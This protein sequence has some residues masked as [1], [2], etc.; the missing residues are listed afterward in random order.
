MNSR[1]AKSTTSPRADVGTAAAICSPVAGRPG[2]VELAR[3]A[4][5]H[6]LAALGD[7]EPYQLLHHRLSPF[8]GNLGASG[9]AARWFPRDSA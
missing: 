2:D 3:H 7:L 4:R 1:S 8:V 5:D 9:A 6:D